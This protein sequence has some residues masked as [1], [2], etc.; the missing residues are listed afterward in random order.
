MI[1]VYYEP[2]ECPQRIRYTLDFLAQHPLAPVEVEWHFNPSKIPQEGHSLYYGIKPPSNRFASFIP[3]QR[4]IFREAPPNFSA[5]RAGQY[6]WQKQTLYSVEPTIK[7]AQAFFQEGLFGFDLLESIFFHV[8][9]IEE[10]HCTPAQRDQW[11]MMLAEAQFLVREQIERLPVVDQLVR[12]FYEALGFE[13]PPR[14][15]SYELSHDIDLICKFRTPARVLRA[16][17]SAL[18]RGRGLAAV[19]RIGRRYWATRTQGEKDPFDSFDWLLLEAAVPKRM[20]VMT[21]GITPHD[22]HYHIEEA[23]I[24]RAMDLAVKRG[25]ELGLHPSYA[26]YRRADLLAEEKER[27]E[28]IGGQVVRSSRQHFLHFAFPETADLLEQ[29]GIEYDSTWGFQDRIGFRCGTGFAYRPYHFAE[30]RS[31]RFWEIPMIVMDSA[32]LQATHFEATAFQEEFWQFVQ[33]LPND[34][35]LTFNFH[36]STFDDTWWADPWLRQLYLEIPSYFE[37]EG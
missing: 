6:T 34:T 19:V 13:L 17:G 32:L 25:Y 5:L 8:S 9:R 27:L 3:A 1:A 36:N 23:T 26:A 37:K 15:T 22:N 2:G 24:R 28:R 7:P 18:Y 20:Y 29:S 11:D 10:Y 31:Y 21:G 16:M 4:L 14:P 35:H 30:K 12:A 33:S